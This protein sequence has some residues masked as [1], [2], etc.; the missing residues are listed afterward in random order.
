M[1]ILRATFRT[2]HPNL[3]NP[4]RVQ[5][6]TIKAKKLII[7]QSQKFGLW[8]VATLSMAVSAGGLVFLAQSDFHNPG[9]LVPF[10]LAAL[11]LSLS[12][13]LTASSIAIMGSVDASKGGAAGSLEATGYELGTGLGIT[14]FGVFMSSVFSRAIALPPGLPRDLSQQASKTIGDAYIVANQ[15]SGEQ[16]AA[17]IEAPLRRRTPFS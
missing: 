3:Q 7:E 14:L 9:F 4:W 8:L 13:G 11:G 6:T 5:N 10:A 2:A 1:T 12:I 15:L 16:G 17:V